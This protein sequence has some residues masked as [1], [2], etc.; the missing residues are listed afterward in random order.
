M[1]AGQELGTLISAPVIDDHQFVR[2]SG[3][4]QDLV[5]PLT[6]GSEIVGFVIHRN[7]QGKVHKVG[8]RG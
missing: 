2:P 7:N 8:V 6:E 3:R 4:S 1:Q 5:N